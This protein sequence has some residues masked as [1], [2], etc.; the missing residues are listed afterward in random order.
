MVYRIGTTNVE[1]NFAH[2]DSMSNYLTAV[3]RLETINEKKSKENDLSYLVRSGNEILHFFDTVCG[4]GAAKAAFGDHVDIR[5][6]FREYFAF[7]D[8]VKAEFEAVSKEVLASFPAT[9]HTNE[10]APLTNDE[11][12]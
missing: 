12:D 7:I 2:L 5:E 1:L 11:A 3:D 4:E 8:A 6:L 10:A 9:D